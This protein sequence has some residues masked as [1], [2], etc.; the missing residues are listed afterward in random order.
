[1]QKR[2]HC[3]VEFHLNS[4]SPRQSRIRRPNIWRIDL[5]STSQSLEMTQSPLF[6]A[7]KKWQDLE[8]N[9]Y[10]TW[11]HMLYIYDC[12]NQACFADIGQEAEVGSSGFRRFACAESSTKLW[13]NWSNWSTKLLSSGTLRSSIGHKAKVASKKMAH[14]LRRQRSQKPPTLCCLVNGPDMKKKILYIYM[15]DETKKNIYLYTEYM[16]MWNH[17]L[18]SDQ[19]IAAELGI[20]H[21]KLAAVCQGRSFRTGSTGRHN[22]EK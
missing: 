13:S 19:R 16:S 7:R 4:A 11:Y 12:L 20:I 17:H 1:M 10:T 2:H 15:K 22:T 6:N 3:K 18:I 21:I 5:F 8:V 14:T 9:F